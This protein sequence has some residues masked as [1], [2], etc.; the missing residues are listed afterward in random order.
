MLYATNVL[1][2][3]KFLDHEVLN[4]GI[5]RTQF[6]NTFEFLRRQRKEKTRYKYG[7]DKIMEVDKNLSLTV[8]N[9]R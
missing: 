7:G 4:D 9:I 1:Q 8:R 3:G 5:R 2:E 6:K